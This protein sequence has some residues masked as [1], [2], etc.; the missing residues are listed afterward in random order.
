ME[1]TNLK[2]KPDGDY[3]YRSGDSGQIVEINVRYSLGGTNFLSGNQQR[4]GVT[5]SVSPC[6]VGEYGFTYQ[7]MGSARKSGLRFFVEQL[8]RK[9]QK[10]T[11]AAAA[12]LDT[13]LPKV[14]ELWRGDT[15]TAIEVM[16]AAISAFRAGGKMEVAPTSSSRI[17]TADGQIVN[18]LPKNDKFFELDE[19]QAAV[20]GSIEFAAQLADGSVMY[21]NE[22]GK[23]KRLGE[24]QLATAHWISAHDEESDRVVGDVI[25]VRP[26]HSM[27]D[28]EQPVGV[29]E[30]QDM[31]QASA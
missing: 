6:E 25:I 10:R 8:A 31:V 19:L 9:N 24:N 20:G 3:R 5:V 13:I 7:L 15:G 11:D 26:E 27:G 4:R 23:L 22:E 29:L 18:T 2:M 12:A 17:I 21:C 16:R 1:L 28:H 30:T 14:A